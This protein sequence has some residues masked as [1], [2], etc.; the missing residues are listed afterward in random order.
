MHGDV[1]AIDERADFDTAVEHCE[2][3]IESLHELAFEVDGLVLKVNDLGQRE[4]LGATT[5][6]PR[7]VIAYKFEKY[8][9]PTRVREIA[10]N[11]GKRRRAPLWRSQV[12]Q[13]FRKPDRQADWVTAEAR[14]L[15]GRPRSK[16]P[17]CRLS[18]RR[19]RRPARG[20]S[21]LTRLPAAP[22]GCGGVPTG[23]GDG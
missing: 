6:S 1:G 16:K 18:R 3:L 20:P 15:L 21:V 22:V 10:V 7:W 4:R 9:G 12:F 11:V 5:K 17:Q 2:E 14:R 8:E 13:K 23:F 19:L